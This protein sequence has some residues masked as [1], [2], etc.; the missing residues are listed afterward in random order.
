MKKSKIFILLLVLFICSLTYAKADDGFPTEE[1]I[2]NLVTAAWKEHPESID[3]TFYLE[4]TRPSKPTEQ[5]RREVEE[6]FE[7]DMIASGENPHPILDERTK[8]S[9]EH[10]VQRRIKIQQFPR[11]I[12]KRIR[13]SNHN[14]RV[15]Q[16]IAKPGEGLD[17]NMPFD[18]TYVNVGERNN[19][20]FFSFEYE[21]K[22]KS[23]IIK[24]KGFVRRDPAGVAYMPSGISWLL[25]SGLG[26]NQGTKTN[27]D[28][29]PDPNKIQEFARTG[30]LANRFIFK[31][32]P[33]INAPDTRDRIEIKDS[34]FPNDPGNIMIC[35]RADYSRVYYYKACLPTTGKVL[36]IRECSN[37]D[38][39]GFP[40][41]ITEIQL[42]DDSN[43]MEK[44]GYR[45][46]KVELNPVIPDEVFKFQPPDDYEVDD[47]R[48]PEKQPKDVNYLTTADVKKAFSQMD[49]AFQKKDLATL[50]EFLKHKSWRVRSNALGLI[51]GVAKVE[52]LKK[53]VESVKDDKSKEVREQAASILQRIESNK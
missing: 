13:I 40:R 39:K 23:A 27:P 15:D 51:T 5:I 18:G 25:K 20:D 14:Q 49:N 6:D 42:P 12:K 4:W 34:N 28:F 30:I 11:L 43:L 37:F 53:I 2:Q 7:K 19:K 24:N 50:K 38:S 9:I 16:V 21:H 52:E 48:P 3:V 10:N 41:N 32:F 33:D 45:I 22:I 29:V 17:P 35:D 8:E 44:S 36:Y 31:I 26:V 46:E 47:Q 1:Q